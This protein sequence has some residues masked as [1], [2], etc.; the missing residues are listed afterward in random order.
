MLRVKKK[1]GNITW[2]KYLQKKIYNKKNERGK[3]YYNI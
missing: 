1:K 3:R 2:Y